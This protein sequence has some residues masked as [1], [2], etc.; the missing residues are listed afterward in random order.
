M[1]QEVNGT[2]VQTLHTTNASGDII[3]ENLFFTGADSLNYRFHATDHEGNTTTKDIVLAIT[4]P[5]ITITNIEKNSEKAAT[6][7]AELSQDVDTGTVSFQKNRNGYWVGL[8]ANPSLLSEWGSSE[9]PAL[10]IEDYPL[11]SR[12]TTITG[13]YYSLND[14]I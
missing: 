13:Q 5:D 9:Q 14:K 4:I 8:A 1:Q 2:M 12:I 3:I 10:T 11:S 6:I 7:T